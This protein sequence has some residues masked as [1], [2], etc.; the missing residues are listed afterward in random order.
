LTAAEERRGGGRRV[1]EKEIPWEGELDNGLQVKKEL[2]NEQQ[3][4][5]EG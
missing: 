2:G 1:K 3:K 5:V 4:R